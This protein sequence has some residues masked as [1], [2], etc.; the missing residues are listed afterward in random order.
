ML[1]RSQDKETIVEI[2]GMSLTIFQT[3]KGTYG[4]VAS[5]NNQAEAVEYTLG[6]YATKER[7]MEIEDQILTAYNYAR[8]TYQ[9]PK[10]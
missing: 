1:I 3:K 4:I 8:R 7:A 2:T 6:C 5:S 10:E 9:I